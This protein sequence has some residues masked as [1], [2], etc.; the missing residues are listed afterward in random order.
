ML[1]NSKYLEYDKLTDIAYFGLHVDGDGNIV[2]KNEKGETE[3]GYDNWNNSNQLKNVMSKAKLWK[4]RFA[5]TIIAQSDDSIDKLMNCEACQTKLMDSVIVELKSK[6]IKDVNFDFEHSGETTNQISDKY[7]E[8]IGFANTKLDKEFGDSKV[9]VASFADSFKRK[10]ITNPTKLATVA[11]SLFIM[12]YDFHQ[13]TSDRAGPVAPL[14]GAP[15]VYDYD[16]ETSI[17]DYKKTVSPYKLILGVPYYGYNFLIEE[18]NPN[19]K[20]IPGSDEDGFSISQ[21]YAGIKDNKSIPIQNTKLDPVSQTP[22]I[23]YKSAETQKLRVLHFENEQSLKK[24]YEFALSENLS[25][26]GIWALG[27]DGDYKELW[28][29]LGE[30]FKK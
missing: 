3:P 24:K 12:A 20:R 1:Q 6:H 21:Y 22:Y 28:N 7:T 23:I 15:E 9:V 25:G 30:M 4:V 5:L 2:K 26:V 17:L 27:Y 16:V 19:A 10:R 18:P 8:F 29:V 11:D 14:S 13:P